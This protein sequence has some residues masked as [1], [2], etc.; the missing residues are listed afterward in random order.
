[1]T[2]TLLVEEILHQ[3]RLVVYPIIYKVLYIPGGWPWDFWTINSISRHGGHNTRLYSVTDSPSSHE[4]GFNVVLRPFP[5]AHLLGTPDVGTLHTR[6]PQQKSTLIMVAVA[7][8][9][10]RHFLLHGKLVSFFHMFSWFNSPQ[11]SC[12]CS[13]NQRLS[14]LDN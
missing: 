13:S 1:M 8:V 2:H 4:K 6:K 7:L 3:L 5:Q 10:L 11:L 12:D 9:I 14:K